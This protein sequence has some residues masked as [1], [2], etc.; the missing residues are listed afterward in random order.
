M[1]ATMLSNWYSGATLLA[2][3]LN[4]HSKITCNGE[5]FPFES[6]GIDKYIC[7]CGK[8]LFECEFFTVAASNMIDKERLEWNKDFFVF[9]PQFSKIKPI[10]RWLKSFMHLHKLRDIVINLVPG[11]RVKVE[12]LI[13]NHLQFF[14]KACEIDRS[15]VY[16][17][18][19]KSV[20]R[21]EL[22][23][24]FLKSNIKVLYL[25][26]D[27][28]AFCY[29][30]IKNNH[31]TKDKLP[32][33]AKAWLEY[34]ELIDEFSSRYP[35]V[36]I[37]TIRYEDLCRNLRKALSEICEFLDL[38]VDLNMI[39]NIQ[40]PYHIFGNVMRKHFN[41]NVKEALSWKSEL[42]AGEIDMI[43]SFMEKDLR[44]FGYL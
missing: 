5:A 41:G 3:L 16:I 33:A 13:N 25:V 6:T 43:T 8:P 14:M 21:A 2:I 28:R 12:R 38:P 24:K 7:S 4:N 22:F 9:L 26:R 36:Q 32:E 29:S 15:S 44:R 42:T 19:T 37:M 18:G 20:R 34:I 1:F 40:K 35:K 31:F 23:A 39:D 11:Y 30:Y 27:G 17:D 10:D